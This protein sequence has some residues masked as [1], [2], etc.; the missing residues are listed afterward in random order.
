MCSRSGASTA[1]WGPSRGS[2]T[3]KH[4]TALI[5]QRA[6]ECTRHR[7]AALG[8]GRPAHCE[9][10]KYTSYYYHFP[11][12]FL[13]SSSIAVSQLPRVSNEGTGPQALPQALSPPGSVPWL[14]PFLHVHL[15]WSLR[16]PG[17][18]GSLQPAVRSTDSLHLVSTRE[19]VRAHGG[20]AFV[21]CFGGH[22]SGESQG[23]RVWGGVL[24]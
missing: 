20:R 18:R 9:R 21:P 5:S 7:L 17:S 24:I 6:K 11:H 13:K 23:S 4:A 8:A 19:G 12:Q 22:R 14:T 15:R 1:L 3:P 16:L 2:R 10:S